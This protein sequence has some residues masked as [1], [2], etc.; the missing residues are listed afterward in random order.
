MNNFFL[1]LLLLSISC[2]VTSVIPVLAAIGKCSHMYINH[3]SCLLIASYVVVMACSLIITVV[4]GLISAY[5]MFI[6][7]LNP[8]KVGNKN[9]WELDISIHIMY[10]ILKIAMYNWYWINVRRQIAKRQKYTRK[11]KYL[12][13][14][15]TSIILLSQV[16]QTVAILFIARYSISKRF[17]MMIAYFGLDLSTQI[18][19]I[20]I[21]YKQLKDIQKFFRQVRLKLFASN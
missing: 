16:S 20:V 4:N 3:T 9:L 21:W 8:Q 12:D 11:C 18:I 10:A 6:F 2:A 15:W 14:L 1:T 19:I 13:N 5:D 7:H 17:E